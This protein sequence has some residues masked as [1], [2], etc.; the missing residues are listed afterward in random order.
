M[1]PA[2][3]QPRAELCTGC[4]LVKEGGCTQT[5]PCAQGPEH[6]SETESLPECANLAALLPRFMPREEREAVYSLKIIIGYENSLPLH[7]NP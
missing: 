3:G 6:K 4:R 2:R 5:S 7:S 1:Y